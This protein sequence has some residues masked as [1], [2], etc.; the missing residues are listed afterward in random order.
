M[1]RYIAGAHHCDVVVPQVRMHNIPEMYSSGR[2]IK[3]L[4][5]CHLMH[6]ALFTRWISTALC[7][8]TSRRHK[9]LRT[10]I[11]VRVHHHSPHRH[12]VLVRVHRAR[13]GEVDV[14]WQYLD[15]V[16]TMEYLLSIF[17]IYTHVVSARY[18]QS[19]SFNLLIVQSGKHGMNYI[20]HQQSALNL[21]TLH[22]HRYLLTQRSSGQQTG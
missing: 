12:L 8:S 2:D 19:E 20:L 18:L 17:S 3:M 10:H 16:F 11:I 9:S 1:C 14:L 6:A 13:D 22:L 4:F 21:S 15:T 7:L 5:R